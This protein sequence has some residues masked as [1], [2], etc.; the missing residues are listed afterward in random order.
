MPNGFRVTPSRPS[1]PPSPVRVPPSA[2]SGDGV[3]GV[4][5]RGE[6]GH[7]LERI[8]AQDQRAAADAAAQEG[9]PPNAGIA[10]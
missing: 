9:G 7:V 3:V 2:R 10:L 6:R 5:S 1:S 8:S 4:D